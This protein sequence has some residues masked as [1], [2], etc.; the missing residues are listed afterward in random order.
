MASGGLGQAI[1]RI[2]MKSI[3]I[4]NGPNLNLLG[5]RQTHIYGHKSLESINASIKN[6]YSNQFI[7]DFFQSNHEGKIIDYIQELQ[8]CHAIII[9]PGAFTHTSIAIRDAILAK[10]IATIEVHL[11]NIFKREPFRQKSYFS[12]IS[13]GVISGFGSVGYELAID[14]LMNIKE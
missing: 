10:D 2:N 4:I 7:I 6:K 3:S 13:L 14:A 5:A 8:N 11:S 1:L 9:N 12:D